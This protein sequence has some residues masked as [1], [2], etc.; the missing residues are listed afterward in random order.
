MFKAKNNQPTN[1]NKQTNKTILLACLGLQCPNPA[2]SVPFSLNMPYTVACST[3]PKKEI[4]LIKRHTK[5]TTVHYIKHYIHLS[6]L[7]MCLCLPTLSEKITGWDFPELSHIHQ[8]EIQ[9][10]YLCF[11]NLCINLAVHCFAWLFK[12]PFHPL[13]QNSSFLTTKTVFRILWC[14]KLFWRLY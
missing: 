4:I 1:H 14:Q 12:S 5:Y 8:V 2:H 13:S 10:V 11:A 3:P 7:D 9:L 6:C